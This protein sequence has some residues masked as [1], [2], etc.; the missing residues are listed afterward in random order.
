[1]CLFKD[2]FEHCEH[3]ECDIVLSIYNSAN[4]QVMPSQK[5]MRKSNVRTVSSL[6]SREGISSK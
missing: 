3:P 1:M 6:G 4:V 5:S 2:I